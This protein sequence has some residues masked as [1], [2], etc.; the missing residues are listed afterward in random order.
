VNVKCS[1][2]IAQK[3]NVPITEHPTGGHD[4][5]VDDPSWIAQEIKKSI[6]AP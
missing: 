3:W 6:S 4:L 1:R 2:A 5:S